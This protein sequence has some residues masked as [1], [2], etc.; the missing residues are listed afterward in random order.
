MFPVADLLFDSGKK[1]DLAIIVSDNDDFISKVIGAVSTERTIVL[2]SRKKDINVREEVI[3]YTF[4]KNLGNSIY[5]MDFIEKLIFRIF[6]GGYIKGDMDILLLSD[7][8][9]RFILEFNS[10]AMPF[11]RV[12]EELSDVVDK[13]VMEALLKV[14]FEIHLEGREGKHIGT[15][16]IVGDTDRVLEMSKQLVINPYNNQEE[17]VRSILKKENWESIK[18]LAQIDGAFVLDPKGNV[19]C[20][21]RYILVDPQVQTTGGLGGRHLAAASITYTTNSVS[22]ALSSSGTVRIFRKGKVV[23][24]EDLN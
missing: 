6:L 18:E 16:F 2:T 8:P 17:N 12:M 5:F 21:G 7:Y 20:A 14:I 19:L 23:L 22:F 10:S 1:H 4:N 11:Y 15:L 9:F 13:E 3:Y 24:K